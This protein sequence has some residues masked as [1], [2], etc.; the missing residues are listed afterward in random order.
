[1]KVLYIGN[2]NDGTGW[3]NAA[4]NN[5][6]AM[7]KVGIDV[8]PRC[9]TYNNTSDPHEENN[10]IKILE[11]K[12]CINP[13]VCIQHVLPHLYYYNSNV[14]NIGYLAVESCDFKDS[15]WHKYCNLMDEIWVPSTY[16]KEA[17]IKSKVNKPIKIIPHC[18][19][20]DQYINFNNSNIRQI[21]EL[22]STFNFVFIGEFIERKNIESLVRAFHKEFHYKEPVNLL[23]KTSGIDYNSIKN[24]CDKIKHGL[25]LRK[26]YKEEIVITG[27]LPFND[28]LSVL[29]QCHCFI[30]PSRGEGFCI[31][32][33]ETML[34]GIPSIYTSNTGM[35]DFSIGISVESKKVPCFGGISSLNNLYTANTYWMDIDIDK[36]GKEMRLMF[37]N[38]STN[39]YKQMSQDCI[40]LSKSYSFE[41]IGNKIKKVLN[42]S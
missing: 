41:G 14:K 16:C 10:I 29:K 27:H 15:M 11:N 25:K 7:H 37:L 6:L 9:I 38:S 5:I 24:Y 4:K 26:K 34:L 1:M 3:G 36:L 20:V 21:Q 35:D 17:C 32:S 28:Y 2:Y 8:I 40:N 42:D 33:L 12:P 22:K 13:D 30:M 19:N 23:I 31:P 39:K 18:L